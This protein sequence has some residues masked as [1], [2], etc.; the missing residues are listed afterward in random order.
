MVGNF[1]FFHPFSCV[2]WTLSFPL[3]EHP[4]PDCVWSRRLFL[5][6]TWSVALFSVYGK[7][8]IACCYFFPF[9]SFLNVI[10]FLF[11]L[12]AFLFA[13]FSPALDVLRLGDALSS[14]SWLQLWGFL[15]C[16]SL[17]PNLPPPSF[18]DW[19]PDSAS[20]KMWVYFSSSGIVMVALESVCAVCF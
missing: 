6:A 15:C 9:L 14:G 3:L 4:F 13:S 7:V 19:S 5:G 2:I 11:T 1:P 17:S 12:V 10:A 8:L 16:F 18:S 20:P